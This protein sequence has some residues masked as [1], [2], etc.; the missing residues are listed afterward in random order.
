[1]AQALS[2][3]TVLAGGFL[4]Q[5]RAGERS[6][7][8][9]PPRPIEEYRF[10]PVRFHLLRAPEAP[11]IDTS[12]KRSDVTRILRKANGIWHPAGIHLWAE[13]VVEEP[14]AVV[15]DPH[16][17]SLSS[18]EQLRPLRPMKSRAEGMFHVYY[19]G[20]MGINGIY[21]S[22]EAIFVQQAA[23]L[24]EVEGGIDEPL[25]RVT[26]HELGHALGLEHRQARTNLMA[27]GTTGTSL[28]EAEISTARA[29]C[30]KL[31][32]ILTT[33]AFLDSADKLR[34]GGKWTDAEPRYQ[35]VADLPGDG[36][37]KK[38]A[39]AEMLKGQKGRKG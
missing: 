37:L 3:I 22:R 1:M 5:N 31:D 39:K 28:N 13:S 14:P 35:A 16:R 9:S 29:T 27:S 6:A 20:H 25:P 33:A 23:Q 7:A 30:E 12:L 8:D 17:E 4:F 32:W 15:E 10:V 19:V 36:P 11:A 34:G 21:M 24:V 2:V 18:V 38:R 26:S